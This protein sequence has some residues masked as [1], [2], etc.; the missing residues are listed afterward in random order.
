MCRETREKS[1]SSHVS[2]I[3]KCENILSCCCSSTV[4]LFTKFTITIY[5]RTVIFKSSKLDLSTVQP[6]GHLWPQDVLHARRHFSQ[7]HLRHPFFL[8][9]Y[10]IDKNLFFTSSVIF[11][12]SLSRLWAWWPEHHSSASVPAPLSKKFG[13]QWG[14]TGQKPCLPPCLN[15]IVQYFS[16][17]ILVLYIWKCFSII[18]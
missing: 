4:T 13:T 9:F 11:F 16:R 6:Q 8:L 7:E 1:R 5:T 17:Y 10:F 3:T 2:G 14:P 18:F 12:L 15:S